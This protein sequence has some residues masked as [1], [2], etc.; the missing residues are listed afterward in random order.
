MQFNLPIGDF[1]PIWDMVFEPNNPKRVDVDARRINMF[2]LSPY[3]LAGK[4]RKTPMPRV[5]HKIV[6]HI[7]GDDQAAIN[8]LFN[9]LDYI[10]QKRERP[11]T[12]WIWYGRPE[13][14]GKGIFANNVLRPLLGLGQTAIRRGDELSQPY[15]GFMK[16]TM[17]VFF[18]E[19]HVAEMRDA[20]YVMAK[21]RNFITEPSVSLAPHALQRHGD[22]QLRRHHLPVQQAQRHHTA[23][24]RPPLEHWPVSI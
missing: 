13:G 6:R 21:L 11:A 23:E 7:L 12:G 5:I 10:V 16:N 8:H 17:L 14:A 3:M 9:W 4:A 20:E 18:D 2:Q 1:I 22:S 24:K 15:N 19:A